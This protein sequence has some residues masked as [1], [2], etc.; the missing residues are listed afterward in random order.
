MHQT[1]K[2]GDS[3]LPIDNISVDFR[4]RDSEYTSSVA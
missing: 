1:P 3:V 2:Q 4:R